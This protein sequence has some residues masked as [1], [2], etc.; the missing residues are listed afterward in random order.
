MAISNSQTPTDDPFDKAAVRYEGKLPTAANE[1]DPT[2]IRQKPERNAD[3]IDRI[4][5]RIRRLEDL[6]SAE[7]GAN[8][9]AAAAQAAADAAQ[10][11]ADTAQ[12]AAVAAQTSID[13]ATIEGSCSGGDITVTFTPG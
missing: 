4:Y 9:A 5:A 6:M 1:A 12:A 11:D 2:I 7:S 3:E 10:A 13:D 8:A